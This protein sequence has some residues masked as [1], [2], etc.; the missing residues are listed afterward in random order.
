MKRTGRQ[1]ILC[2]NCGKLISGDVS[3]CPY[4]NTAHPGAAWKNIIRSHAFFGVDQIV[5]KIIYANIVMYI[6]SLLLHPGMSG[7]SANPLRLLAPNNASLILLGATGT[8]PI[9]RLH[10]WWSLISASYLHGSILHILFN[11]VALWQLGP[12]VVQEFGSYRMFIIYTLSG[13]GGY[14][15]SYLAGIPLTIGASASI[16]GLMGALLYFGKSLGGHYGH[17]MYKQVSGWVIALFLFGFIVP[18]IN[19]WGHGGGML[20]GAMLG[21]ALGYNPKSAETLVHKTAAFACLAVTGLAL[22]WAV[23]TTVLFYFSV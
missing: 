7:F 11:M 20:A 19:N 17:A 10:R 4:C 22:A 12:L 3:R 15:L 6:L 16:C 21:F 14:I 5:R 9:D 23:A 13:V 2:P 18:G 8:L 1:S